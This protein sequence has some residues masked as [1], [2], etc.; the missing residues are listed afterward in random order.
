MPRAKASYLQLKQYWTTI[1]ILF[2]RTPIFPYLLFK[3]R[4]AFNNKNIIST[5]NNQMKAES[6]ISEW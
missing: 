6:V 3:H 2:I 1:R 5:E 4:N